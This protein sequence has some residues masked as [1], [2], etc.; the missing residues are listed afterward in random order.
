MYNS[1]VISAVSFLDVV[2]PLKQVGC[3]FITPSVVEARLPPNTPVTV[4]NYDLSPDDHQ[5]SEPTHISLHIG[6]SLL[7]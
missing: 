4:E 2:P 1:E 6:L 3:L 5:P 7:L